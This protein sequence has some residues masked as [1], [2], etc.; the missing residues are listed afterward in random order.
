MT[1]FYN[2]KEAFTIVTNRGLTMQ[3]AL[4]SHGI[5]HTE[6]EDL[7]KAYKTEDFIY[8]DD[9]GELQVDWEGL[10]FNED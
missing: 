10:S 9:M 6:K 3:E 2:G 5:D 4:Y 1:V 7:E 8:R